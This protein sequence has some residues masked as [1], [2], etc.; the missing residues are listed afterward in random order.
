MWFGTPKGV[1]AMSQKGWRSYTGN[2]GLPSEDINCLLQDST[3][4][5][6]IGTAEGLAYLSDGHVH[7]PREVPG[8]LQGPIFGIEE[9]KNG[10]L[11]I[12][13]SDHVLRVQR[14]KLISGMVKGGDIRVY[15]QA[16]GLESTEGV[17]RSQS[18]GSDS[19]GRIWFSLS[20]GLSV[21]N[22]SRTTDD[23]VP[24]LPHIEVIAAD[25]N[26]VDLATSVRIPPSPRRI[27]I[28]YAGL[29][30]A[31]PGRIRFRYFLEV[32]DRSWSQPVAARDAVNT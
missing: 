23:S 31:V 21:V 3:R 8:S 5:L 16:D 32:F 24:A 10:R 22:P 19:T 9:D 7:V 20:R 25:N 30:L 13:T 4:I 2:D 27:T 14:D 12:A 6:W 28:E 11:W 15:D 18:V 29:S 1:S 17:K 26:T